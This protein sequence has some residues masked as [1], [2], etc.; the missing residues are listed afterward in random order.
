MATAGA[1]GPRMATFALGARLLK[2]LPRE[3]ILSMADQAVVS[4]GT[5]LATVAVARWG[6]PYQLGAYSIGMSALFPLLGVQE[7]LIMLPYTIRRNGPGGDA[8]GLARHSLTQSALLAGIAPHALPFSPWSCG[9]PARTSS[10]RPWS[11]RLRGWR[12]SFF[13]GNSRGSFASPTCASRRRLRW[14]APPSSFR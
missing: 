12:P 6:S 2:E 4:G 1:R 14:T 3:Q 8:I 9:S 5:F 13:C 11:A 7:A 10:I